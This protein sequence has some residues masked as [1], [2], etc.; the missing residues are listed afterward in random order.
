[1]LRTF[2]NSIQINSVNYSLIFHF[3]KV[4][5]EQI[6][7][8]SSL[9]DF[10]RIIIKIIETQ[11]ITTEIVDSSFTMEVITIAVTTASNLINYSSFNFI[12]Q[13]SIDNPFVRIFKSI[14]TVA[15]IAR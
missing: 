1:M 10:I 9:K 5:I 14:A 3:L 13:V 12:I 2:K 15:I 8:N 4:L 11:V 7:I 6:Q